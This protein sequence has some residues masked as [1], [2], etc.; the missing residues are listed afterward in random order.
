MVLIFIFFSRTQ[1]CVQ[2]YEEKMEYARKIKDFRFGRLLF[3][4]RSSLG[5]LSLIARWERDAIF[6]LSP[7]DLRWCYLRGLECPS[8]AGLQGLVL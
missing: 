3:V 7:N 5:H 8:F 4:S 2:R 6:R 1:N